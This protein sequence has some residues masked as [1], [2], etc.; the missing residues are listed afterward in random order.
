MVDSDEAYQIGLKIGEILEDYEL[1]SAFENGIRRSA[2]VR[3]LT[4][5]ERGLLKFIIDLE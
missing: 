2:C 5:I 4:S 1:C 3:G